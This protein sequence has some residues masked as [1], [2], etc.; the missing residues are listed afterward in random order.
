MNH[1]KAITIPQAC[2]QSWQQMTTVNEGRHCE[3]CC[4]TVVDF[5]KMD[6][7][8]IIR[9]LSTSSNTCGRFGQQQLGSL[10]Y[11]LYAKNLPKVN[12]WK[13][14]MV[15]VGMLGPFLSHRANAQ[16]KPVV[17]NAGDANYDGNRSGATVGKIAVNRMI[18]ITG[19]V[20]AKDDGLPIPGT[21]I[22]IKGT[23]TGTV[24]NSAGKF[25][26][27]VKPGYV[28]VASFV[29]YV[30]QQVPITNNTT[31]TL[32]I[33]LQTNNSSMGEV[34]VVGVIK[35]TPKCQKAWRRVKGLLGVHSELARDSDI[36][37]STSF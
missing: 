6:N 30:T 1:I 32:D 26:I 19:K 13:R 24:T 18:T 35:T 17:V 11:A 5:T 20:I 8:E 9:Y 21:V 27:S 25:T 36:M 14:A 2:H 4:K 16:V 34:V 12:W 31:N 33:A 23:T 15:F 37:R 29:G 22:K 3:H 28:L 7:D 10:N